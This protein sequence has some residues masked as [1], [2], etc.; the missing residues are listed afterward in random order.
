MNNLIIKIIESLKK[1][2]KKTEK[3][4]MKILQIISPAVL[5]TL[6]APSQAIDTECKHVEIKVT[7]TILAYALVEFGCQQQRI[8]SVVV[9]SKDNAPL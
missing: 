9:A 6:T 2:F 1:S 4:K 3:R 5:T 8:L 7:Q